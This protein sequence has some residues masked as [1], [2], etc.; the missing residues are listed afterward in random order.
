MSAASDLICA[1]SMSRIDN[2]QTVSWAVEIIYNG[3]VKLI[4]RICPAANS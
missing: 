3:S 1:H 2:V 4:R